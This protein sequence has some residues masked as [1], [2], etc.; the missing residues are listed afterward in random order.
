MDEIFGSSGVGSAPPGTIIS[1]PRFPSQ[2]PQPSSM[3]HVDTDDQQPGPSTRPGP[4]HTKQA[5]GQ[6]KGKSRP[7]I[8]GTYQAHAER[9]TAALKSLVRPEL[10]RLRRLKE[11]RSFEKKMITCMGGILAQLKELGKQQQ[12]IIALLKETPT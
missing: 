5:T 9:R 6:K 1:T 12:E 2:T 10:A 11:R 3:E 8:E 7:L 4:T